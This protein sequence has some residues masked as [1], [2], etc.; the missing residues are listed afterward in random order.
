MTPLCK[1]LEY[2][3]RVIWATFM[4]TYVTFLSI[5]ELDNHWSV[6]SFLEKNSINLQ[7]FEKTAFCDP[8][9]KSFRVNS[10]FERRSADKLINTLNSSLPLFGLK[11][12][13]YSWLLKPDIQPMRGVVCEFGWV[14]VHRWWLWINIPLSYFLKTCVFLLGITNTNNASWKKEESPVKLYPHRSKCIQTEL[15]DG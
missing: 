12:F 1:H 15:L 2:R 5:L 4:I 11:S 6:S 8:L 13:L 3:V 10:C 9:K 7:T 14:C